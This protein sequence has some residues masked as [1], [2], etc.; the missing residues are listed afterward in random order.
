MFGYVC[1]PLKTV[2]WTFVPMLVAK[3]VE[4]DGT[5]V[6]LL[7]IKILSVR[8]GPASL[9]VPGRKAWLENTLA[10]PTSEPVKSWW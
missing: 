6:W 4:M 3:V 7:D 5:A 10:L 8:V 2:V 9:R 1:V